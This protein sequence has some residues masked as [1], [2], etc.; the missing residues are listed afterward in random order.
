MRILF[1]ST[2]SPE[3]Y[4]DIEREQR[5]L[6][7][8]AEGHGHMLKFLPG[9]QVSDIEAELA[10]RNGKHTGFDV[11]HFAGHGTRQGLRLRAEKDDEF[12]ELGGDRLARLLEASKQSDSE[13]PLKL[14]VLNACS[15]ATIAERIKND[16]EEVIGTRWDIKDR[17]AR[18]FSSTLYEGLSAGMTVRE[19]FETAV[20]DEEGPYMRPEKD[21]A[22]IVKLP[23][24]EPSGQAE[25][26]GL[27]DFYAHYYG[28]YIDAQIDKLQRDRRLNNYVFY[29][30]IGIAACFWI[31]LLHKG[32][33]V[34]EGA[35]SSN[36]IASLET[37]FLPMN[38]DGEPLR[39]LSLPAFAA[40]IQALEAYAPLLIAFF[41]KRISAHS[42]PKIEGLERLKESVLEWDTLPDE[43]RDMIRSVMHS[44]LEESLKDGD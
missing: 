30:L 43:E 4:L 42:A 41:Q 31:Y 3:D 27:D 12:D 10:G 28:R 40:R 16:V 23:R 13:R 35:F 34:P 20:G 11:L 44:A 8:L 5:S 9:A 19:A 6:L 32:T 14:V 29:G 2:N 17:R 1:V 37:L 24:A 36:L 26:E 25:V 33:L 21:P 18:Q 7:K 38:D 22:P 15:T 39:V